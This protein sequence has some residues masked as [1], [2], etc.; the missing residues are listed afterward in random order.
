[1]SC[2]IQR[3]KLESLQHY[4]IPESR[5]QVEQKPF[6]AGG[7]GVVKKA[8]LLPLADS[9]VDE[10]TV[11]VKE[12]RVDTMRVIPLRAAYRLVREMVVWSTCKHENILQFLGYHLGE[13][14]DPAYLISPHMENGN[15][16]D[17]L[18]AN[19][20]DNRQL[21]EWVQDTLSGLIYLH[22]QDP[23]IVHGDLKA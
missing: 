6:G 12:L 20:V 1:M 17:Y 18:A 2:I 5:L 23:P 3:K 13:N 7:F 4:F 11:A 14:F 10:V 21:L 9:S 19:K 16:R 15:V 8:K 22:S